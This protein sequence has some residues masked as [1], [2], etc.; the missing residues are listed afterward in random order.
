MRRFLVCGGL[1]LVTLAPAIAAT[2]TAPAL[3][4][5]GTTWTVNVTPDAAAAAKGEKPFPDVLMFSAGR[6]AMSECLKYGFTASRYT[7]VKAGEGWTFTTEQ[8]SEKMGKSIW[9]ADIMGDSIKG[10]MV[11]TKLDGTILNYSFS[12][13][14]AEKPAGK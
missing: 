14:K 3:P 5:D 7:T 9:S 12:G 2:Q 13:K 11:S 8:T 6:V 4:L 10:T 1:L